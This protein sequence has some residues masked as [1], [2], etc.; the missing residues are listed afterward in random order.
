VLKFTPDHEWL[1]VREN[2]AIVG[3]TEH[4]QQQLGELVFVAL[5]PSGKRFARGAP[6]AVVESIK[7]TS[8]VGAPISG[9]V[10]ETNQRIVDDPT[11]VNSDPL[12]DGWFFKLKI[13]DPSEIDLLMG[14]AT[15][16][17]HCR[18]S[19]TLPRF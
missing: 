8:H 2:V 10:I 19:R 5:P 13:A 15:Y 12:G 4:A 11:L 18:Y 6:A 9:Q 1:R 3:I 16:K 17:T 7:A 14:E